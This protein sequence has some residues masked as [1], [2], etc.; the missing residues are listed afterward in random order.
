MKRIWLNTTCPECG[1]DMYQELGLDAK[2]LNLKEYVAV[3]LNC[4]N[5]GRAIIIRVRRN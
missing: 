5:C 1:D 4:P 2:D 3:R